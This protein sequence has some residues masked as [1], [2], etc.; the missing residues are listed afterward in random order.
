MKLNNLFKFL[1]IWILISLVGVYAFSSSFFVNCG[2][3]SGCK[4]IESD[5]ISAVSSAVKT[6]SPQEWANSF[7]TQSCYEVKKSEANTN[8][9]ANTN[10]APVAKEKVNDLNCVTALLKEKQDELNKRIENGK[11][12]QKA[13]NNK[14]DA[15]AENQK[16]Q[17]T[18]TTAAATPT[19]SP[20]LK[21]KGAVL[22]AE[23]KNLELDQAKLE[24]TRQ[25]A[26]DEVA[27]V[28]KQ[29]ADRYSKRLTFMFFTAAFLLLCLTAILFS[30]YAIWA[31]LTD[32]GT[33][34]EKIPLMWL[35][36]IITAV[37]AVGFFGIVLWKFKEN[38]LSIV[39]PMFNQSIAANGDISLNFIHFFNCIGFGTIIE[40]VGAAGAVFYAVMSKRE[41]TPNRKEVLE[42]LKSLV[43]TKSMEIA[44]ET[45][46]TKKSELVAQRTDLEAHIT[47]LEEPINSVNVLLEAKSTEI[48]NETDETKKSQLEKEKSK[49]EED[50][51]ALE[52][53]K[54][55]IEFQIPELTL[56]IQNA[57]APYKRLITIILYIGALMLF[58]GIVR[59]KLLGDWHLIFVNTDYAK[60]LESFFNIS[61]AVQA[62]FYS[63]LL[64]VVY[65]P[66]VYAIPGSE[67]S[68]AAPEKNWF[69][70]HGLPF[71]AEFM[72]KFVAVFSPLLATPIVDFL[73]AVLGP[74]G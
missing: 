61:I 50:K 56:R 36:Q 25:A 74:A 18:E 48:A 41:M 33:V 49:L 45:D 24:K 21:E 72:T 66:V 47:V 70:R 63:I 22:S 5:N 10:V 62:G 26:T 64:A 67:E 65:L 35:W 52:E 7:D 34:K 2:E 44:I 15:I 69:E 13:I 9:Q 29:I 40:I 20:T 1:P 55:A 23:K 46:A 71:S 39:I 37:C 57:F 11:T 12:N 31:A 17:N 42:S 27:A 68:E 59:V 43:N 8:T 38:Y 28:R 58:V 53:E 16:L 30:M 51:R 19:P 60:L 73:K 4:K 32:M 6:E 3:W 54:R 14:E